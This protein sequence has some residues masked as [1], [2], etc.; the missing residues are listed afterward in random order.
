[1]KIK[2]SLPN[3]EAVKEEVKKGHPYPFQIAIQSSEFIQGALF[4]TIFSNIATKEYVKLD[5]SMDIMEKQFL[6]GTYSKDTYELSWKY[7]G[8]YIDVFRVSIMQSTLISMNSHWDWY[9]RKLSDFIEFSRAYTESPVL[10]GNLKKDF[11]RIGNTSIHHQIEILES[12]TGINFGFKQIDM[13][14]LTE[15]SLI[16]NLGMHNRWEID[17]KYLEKTKIMGFELNEVRV[18]TPQELMTYHESFHRILLETCQK[19]SIK[20]SKA[21][22]YPVK[23]K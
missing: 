14:N 9:I 16:R 4:H 7:F 8:K 12:V 6:E 10:S 18:V 3:V 15:L 23:D 5:G 13:D 11:K 22:E 20:Y 21:P 19:I 1:M 17:A 2:I